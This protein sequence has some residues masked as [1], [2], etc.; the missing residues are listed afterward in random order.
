MIKENESICVDCDKKT[1]DDLGE[2]KFDK[3]GDP[4]CQEHAED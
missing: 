4:H 1:N 2:T 3:S